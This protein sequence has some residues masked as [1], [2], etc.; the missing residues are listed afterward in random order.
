M[1]HAEGDRQLTLQTV[2]IDGGGV[3]VS[4]DRSGARNS[5]EDLERIFQPFVST[6]T[7]G[8]GLGLAVCRTIIASHDGKTL[9]HQQPGFAGPACTSPCMRARRARH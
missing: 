8:M 1:D 2:R 4:V 9:G 7:E 5:P 6:K 3:E